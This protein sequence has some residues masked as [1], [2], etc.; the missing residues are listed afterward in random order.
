MKIKLIKHDPFFESYE[1]DEHI[2]NFK[3]KEDF[4]EWLTENHFNYIGNNMWVHLTGSYCFR[5]P[6]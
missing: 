5:I 6:E 3:D 2:L 4:Q 1:P